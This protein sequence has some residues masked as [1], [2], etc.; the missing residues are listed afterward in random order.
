M[1]RH[2]ISFTMTDALPTVTHLPLIKQPSAFSDPEW[3]FE[4]KHDGFRSL[5]YIEDK[6]RL[7]S[8]NGNTYQRFKELSK[9]LSGVPHEVLLDGE[10]VC[11]DDAGQTLFYDL[12]FNRA[13]VH[14]YAFN[15]LWLDGQDLRERSITERKEILH[16]V[17]AESPQRLLYVDHI[18]AQGEQ[19]FE[20]ICQRDM[21]GVVAKP[22][23]SPYRQ[24]GGKT[25][26]IKI[27]NPDYTQAEGRGELFH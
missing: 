8:R 19:L 11:L 10:L 7:V 17:V 23:G 26:W 5:A 6:C 4:V 25:P 14:F 16:D 9:V 15:I 18:S 22:K 27:K 24:L 20:L 2:I 3:L 1:Q 13:P 21:E 12:M